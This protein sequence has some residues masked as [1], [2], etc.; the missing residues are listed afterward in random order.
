[1]QIGKIVSVAFVALMITLFLVAAYVEL[2]LV[3]YKQDVH[4]PINGNEFIIIVS[5]VYS[6]VYCW[7]WRRL[8]P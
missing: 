6:W 3:L 4:P 5:G 8:Q 1:M 2:V 7:V